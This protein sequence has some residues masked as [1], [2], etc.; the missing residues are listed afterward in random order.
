MLLR[1]DGKS[2]T[3]IAEMLEVSEITVGREIKE[4]L[5]QT[6]KAR[7]ANVKKGERRHRK[8]RALKAEGRSIEQIA[9]EM[10]V[11]PKTVRQVL[12]RPNTELDRQN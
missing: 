7:E 3:E 11:T 9:E 6:E 5:K 10:G 2:T 4:A 12:E 8:M 1:R